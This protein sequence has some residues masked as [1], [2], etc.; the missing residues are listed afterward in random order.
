MHTFDEEVKTAKRAKNKKKY[1]KDETIIK[2]QDRSPSGIKQSIWRQA[3]VAQN[4]LR[5]NSGRNW[6]KKTMGK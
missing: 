5:R 3:G 1:K 2:F 4:G 6:N